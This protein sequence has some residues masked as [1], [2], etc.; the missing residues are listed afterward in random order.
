MKNKRGIELDMIAW[1]LIGVAVLVLAIIAM[2]ILQGKGSSAIDYLKQLLK[3][4]T[5]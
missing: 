2:F 5:K 4:R 3:F 1:L